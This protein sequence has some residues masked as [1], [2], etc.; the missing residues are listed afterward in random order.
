MKCLANS[1]CQGIAPSLV[2]AGVRGI[3]LLATNHDRLSAVAKELEQ[4]N[5]KVDILVSTIDITDNSAVE[6]FFKE[7]KSKWG[8]ADIL[9]NNAGVI[10]GSEDLHE[11]DPL[12]WLSNITVNLQGAFLLTHHFLK[13]LPDPKST[14]ATIVNMTTNVAHMVIPGM[15]GYTTSKLALQ[16][17]TR[18]IA[19]QYPNVAAVSLSPGLV[20][21]DALQ[22][23]FRQF[24]LDT[25]EL[26]G[27]TIVWL[28]KDPQRASFLSGRY[29]CA[30]WSVED[31]VER[32]DE[33]VEKNVLTVDMLGTF[34]KEQFQ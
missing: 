31:L 1:C 3:A 14:P 34:G 9:A 21:T 19:V 16:H 13:A 2:K 6:G 27:G 18:Y 5:P 30:E 22:P 23:F 11:V 28:A 25:P 20:D 32:K 17:L 12:A 15:S 8:H 10:N 33:I 4:L 24:D 29:I 26:T 7:I